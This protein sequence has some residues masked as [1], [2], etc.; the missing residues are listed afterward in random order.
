MACCCVPWSSQCSSEEKTSV[1]IGMH[2]YV[3]TYMCMCTYVCMRVHAMCA[4]M[5][6]CC[7]CKAS[8]QQ[9]AP[10]TKD[11]LWPYPNPPLQGAPRASTEPEGLNPVWRQRGAVSVLLLQGF[12][13]AE[14]ETHS[15]PSA[16]PG[17]VN[18]QDLRSLTTLPTP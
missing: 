7:T 14:H 17:A 4:R 11:F 18:C 13:S 1:S 12:G 3:H 9:Q 16:P 2:A 5:H 15:A 8:A 6:A 10:C